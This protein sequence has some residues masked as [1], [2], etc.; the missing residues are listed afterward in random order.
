M[1]VMLRNISYLIRRILF[2]PYLPLPVS[3]SPQPNLNVVDL[4]GRTVAEYVLHTSISGP[5]P[6][7]IRR[8]APLPS[9]TDIPLVIRFAISDCYG[10]S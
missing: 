1:G 3:I 5:T 9:R 10:R 7:K 2:L 4:A 6:A 8:C